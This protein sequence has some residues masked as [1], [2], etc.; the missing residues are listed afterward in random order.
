MPNTGNP[1]SIAARITGMAYAPVAAGSPGPFDST[2]PCGLWRMMSSNEAFAGTTVTS[3]PIPAN[4][5]KMLCLT[6]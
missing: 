1:A 2:T 3:A 6:P 5:L 4:N